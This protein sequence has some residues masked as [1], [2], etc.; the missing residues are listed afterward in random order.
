MLAKSA[1]LAIACTA[2]LFSAGLIGL[3][4]S[5]RHRSFAAVQSTQ[6]ESENTISEN[7]FRQIQALINEKQSRST[8][9]RKI[10]SQLI[11]AIKANAGQP[12]TAEVTSLDTSIVTV[13]DG[14]TVVDISA[15]ITPP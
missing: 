3:V 15:K 5:Q 4:D 8:A 10:S 14:K 6:L 12:L 13:S 9:L 7:A 1:A 11:Y 2:G